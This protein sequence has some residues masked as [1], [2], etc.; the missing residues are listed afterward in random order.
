MNTTPEGGTDSTES[1]ASRAG[2]GHGGELRR[3]LAC[4]AESLKTA[5]RRP[6]LHELLRPLVRQSPSLA[7]RHSSENDTFYH[8]RI[9]RFLGNHVTWFHANHGA[10]RVK[11]V[12]DPP[13]FLRGAEGCRNSVGRP[14]RVVRADSSRTPNRDSPIGEGVLASNC[15]RAVTEESCVVTPLRRG[16]LGHWGT[17]HRGLWPTRRTILSRAL[18]RLQVATPRWS[19]DYRDKEKTMNTRTLTIAALAGALSLSTVAIGVTA[20]GAAA[21]TPG[22]GPVGSLN[23]EQVKCD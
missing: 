4:V 16:P 17:S 22:S 2:V 1:R 14:P 20:A 12:E 15:T 21:G 18:T 7:L 19:E 23:G 9:R 11:S 8:W 5:E 6:E 3:L 10:P 13:P